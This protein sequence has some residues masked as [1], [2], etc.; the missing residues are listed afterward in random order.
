MLEKS[1]ASL[2]SVSVPNETSPP[3]YEGA[4]EQSI[5]R[6]RQRTAVYQEAKQK[7]HESTEAEAQN[8][9]AAMLDVG[10]SHPDPKVKSDW[11]SRAKRFTRGEKKDREG[12]LSEIGGIVH[13]VLFLPRMV[14]RTAS[15]IVGNT[16]RK[17][18]LVVVGLGDIIVGNSGDA[19]DRNKPNE[20]D[21]KRST[22]E[23]GR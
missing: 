16:V 17:A 1:P 23:C 21:K 6:L 7:G 20:G 3:P 13:L 9:A 4:Y 12:I 14:L 19:I 5:A 10:D 11:Y 15:H 2:E 22:P 8:L 18:G